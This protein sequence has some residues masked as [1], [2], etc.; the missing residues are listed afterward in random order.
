MALFAIN[1]GLRNG[2]VC[3]LQWSWEAKVP[4]LE[5][6]AFVIPTEEFKSNREHV[7]V[8]NAIT[9]SVMKA[10]R[11]QHPTYVVPY[12]D[13]QKEAQADRIETMNNSA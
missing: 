5:C 8:L 2:N 4:D 6:T 12:Q 10:C 3:G 9:R 11:D 13:T 7:V 1:T